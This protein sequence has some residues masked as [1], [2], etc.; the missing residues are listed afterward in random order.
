MARAPLASLPSFRQGSSDHI[1]VFP[2]L[3]DV[4]AQRQEIRLGK[5]P[6]KRFMMRLAVGNFLFC[7]CGFSCLCKF[8]IPRLVV[9]SREC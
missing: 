5:R 6:M 8:V 2:M 9:V 7:A 4:E 3:S 1:D